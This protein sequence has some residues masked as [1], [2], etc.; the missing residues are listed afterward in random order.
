MIRYATMKIAVV[1]MAIAML[2]LGVAGSAQAAAPWWHITQ[3]AAP[4]HLWLGRDEVQEVAF[5]NGAVFELE[6]GKKPVGIFNFPKFPAATAANVQKALE[7][8]YG[9]GNVEVTE[10]KGSE[11]TQLTVKTIGAKAGEAVPPVEAVKLIGSV[12]AKVLT[13]GGSGVLRVRA[14][15]LGD[16]PVD[17]A[18]HPV[19]VADQLPE[20]VVA[21][22]ITGHNTFTAKPLKCQLT[23]LSCTYQEALAPYESLELE[24]EVALPE[25]AATGLPLAK[26]GAQ[27]V[28]TVAGGEAPAAG[29]ARPLTV[30]SEPVGFGVSEYSLQPEEEG[31]APDA[32]AGSHPFQLTTTL[33]FAETRETPNQPAQPRTLRFDLPSGLIG[34]VVSLP[35]CKLID[36]TKALAPFEHNSCPADAVVGVAEVAARLLPAFEPG[37]YRVPVYNLEPSRGEPARFG[38]GIA[39][40]PVTLDVSLRSGNDYGVA[41]TANDAPQAV[42][43]L[44]SVV[45]LWGNPGARVHN[46]SRGWSCLYP[47]ELMEA[48]A[49]SCA[50]AAAPAPSAFLTMPSSCGGPLQSPM[51]ANSWTD[52]AFITPSL[53]SLASVSLDGCEALP[54]TPS[55]EVQSSATAAESPTR[56]TV[57]LKVPQEA[58]QAPEGVAEADVRN[59]TVTLP[60]GLHVNPAAAGGLGACSE[61]QIGFQRLEA[62]GEAIFEEESEAQRLGEAPQRECPQS[63]RLGT[64]RITTPLLEKPLTGY[65]YQAAQTANPFGSLLALYVVAEDRQAGVRVRLA[66]N[67]QTNDPTPGQITSTF[68][69]TPQLPFEEFELRFFGGGR[70]AL[71]TGPCGAYRTD[72]SIESWAGGAA[73]SP[74][75]EFDVGS[76]P[77]GAACSSLGAFA[78]SFAAGGQSAQAGAFTP[79]TTT[80]A[81]RDGEQHL[82]TV[83]LTMPPGLAGMISK[84][85]LCSEAQASAADCPAASQ[86][87]YVRVQAG[88]GSEPITLPQAGRREDPVYLTGPYGGGPFGLA[89]V[90]HPEAGPFN[91]AQGAGTPGER[92]ILVRAKIAVNPHTTQVSIDSEPMPSILQ[93]IPLDVRSVEVVVDRPG[94]MFNPTDCTPMSVNGSVGSVEGA[95]AA[96]SSFFQVANCAS[97][98]FDPGFTAATHAAHSRRGGALL[99]VGVT[100]GPGQANIAKVHVTLPKDLPSRLA[101]LKLACGEAQFAANPSGCPAGSF[102]GTATAHTPVLSSPLSGPAIFVSHGSAA[103]P[104]LDVVLQGEGVTV[105]LEGNTFI[106]KSGFTSSTFA[107]VP[108]MPI[109]SF[110]L[111]LPEGP[112][113]ALAGEGNLCAKAQ[114]MATQITGQNGALITATTKIAVS[115]CSRRLAI[116]SH[117]LRGRTLVV[118]LLLPDAGRV[119]LAG[120]GL[121][122]KSRAAKGRELLTFKLHQRRLGRLATTV[123]ISFK[124]GRGARQ[125][126]RLKVRFKR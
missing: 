45:T 119:T 17:G 1:L 51:T 40:S 74:F 19:T 16:G 67:V 52:P 29:S 54:F 90:V 71:A 79:F 70:A 93:G 23:T 77:G 108:D 63:S 75:S 27:S 49:G 59:T 15:N 121:R 22:S 36:F 53:P 39:G 28:V 65:V 122:P 69:Q 72:A 97:L 50:E 92:P 13:G 113:S 104:N 64:V 6:V 126:R 125:T 25:D 8:A 18:G 9:P 82:S 80:L 20:G 88:V 12:E 73:A 124:P 57:H 120:R 95:S 111:S 76:A 11:R 2:V 116:V 60:A 105:I 43:V 103:F 58:S 3:S 102:V 109:S 107:S 78:P 62:D 37:M 96:V 48:V 94:F 10:A 26:S 42:A 30:S 84:V 56:L 83:A 38:F 46:I 91:L 106:S 101:T 47:E 68:A 21:T 34:N 115:G 7:A 81:R 5:S 98:P 14:F 66:G 33:S 35:Q 99:N 31:G 117:R 61:A 4:A 32:L 24:I 44:S 100:S 110:T 123:K 112:H 86:I 55:L 114:D 87:G 85:P 41:V 89:I 118:K